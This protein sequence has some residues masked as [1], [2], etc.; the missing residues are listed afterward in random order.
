MC[1]IIEEKDPLQL[2]EFRDNK[3]RAI[4]KTKDYLNYI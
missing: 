3:Y 1:T 2:Q 4:I